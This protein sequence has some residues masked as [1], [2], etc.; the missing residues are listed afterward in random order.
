MTDRILFR[1]M[2]ITAEDTV[3]DWV[4]GKPPELDTLVEKLAGAAADFGQGAEQLRKLNTDPWQGEAAEVFRDTVKRL[5]KEL[6]TALDAFVAASLAVLSYRNVL[7]AAQRLT[8]QIIDHDAPVARELS[9]TYEKAVDDY[10]AAARSGDKPATKP[11]E[12]D[13]GR[14]LMTEL[15]GRIQKAK[16]EVEEAAAAARRESGR[17]RAA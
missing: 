7:D 10:N 2:W 13:P 8:Q 16:G 17:W 6:D 3:Q 5:P 1:R 4:P 9:R 12:A 15:V 14:T 11:P